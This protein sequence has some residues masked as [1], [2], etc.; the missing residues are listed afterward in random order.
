MSCERQ[1]F[2]QLRADREMSPPG[3]ENGETQSVEILELGRFTAG[4]LI[5]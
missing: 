1:M 3:G 5:C 2:L 4:A